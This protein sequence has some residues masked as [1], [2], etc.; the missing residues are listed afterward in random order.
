LEDAV[1]DPLESRPFPKLIGGD[2]QRIYYATN[3]GDVRIRF[4]GPTNDLVLP[5]LLGPSNLYEHHDRERALLRPLI[6]AGALSSLTTDGDSVAYVWNTG[7]DGGNVTQQL[8]LGGLFAATDRTVLETPTPDGEVV[9]DVGLA[10]GRLAI[11]LGAT[12]GSGRSRILIQST[13][14]DTPTADIST[15]FVLSFDLRDTRLA[16]TVATDIGGELHLANIATGEDRVIASSDRPLPQVFLSNNF[17]IWSDSTGIM[18]HEIATAAN[19]VWSDAVDGQLVGANDT[20][21]ITQRIQRRDSGAAVVVVE[22]HEPGGKSRTLADFAD[23]G[24]AGQAQVMGER[25]VFVNAD[26]KIVVVPLNG[27]DRFNFEPF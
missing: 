25:V 22:R 2:S 27:D 11:L 26:R 5:G 24:R 21:F 12:D 15:A 17:V 6:L 3:L 8:R 7:I 16:Y 19:F 14:S 23:D 13:F 9:T 18:A 10:S 20:Y 1:A 4:P